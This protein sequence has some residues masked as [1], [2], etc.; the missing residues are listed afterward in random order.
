MTKKF[1][2]TKEWAISLADFL[3]SQFEKEWIDKFK[4]DHSTSTIFLAWAPWAWKTE[5]LE[6]VLISESFMVIDIDKYRCYFEWY[7]WKNADLYQDTSSRVATKIFEYCL[8][9]DLKII[10]DWT[11]TSEIWLKNIKKSLEKNR[12]IWII[13]IYQDPV[14]S[15][16]Y[17]IVRQEN[18][19]RKVSMEAFLRIY[20]NSIKYCFEITKKYKNINFVIWSKNKNRERKQIVFYNKDKFDKYFMVEYNQKALKE[21]LEKLVEK[22]NDWI[23]KLIKNIWKKD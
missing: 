3:I 23:I 18:N 22:D 11:L 20:Y 5:F 17:T 12:K 14:I 8:K 9:K 19:E 21:K 16:W 13:L 10:F 7:N 2:N 15:Y 4:I 1:P 6:T